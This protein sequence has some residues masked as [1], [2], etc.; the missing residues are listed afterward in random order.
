MNLIVGSAQRRFVLSSASF[1]N[2]SASFGTRE[3][4]TYVYSLLSMVPRESCWRGTPEFS[5]NRIS[6]AKLRVILGCQLHVR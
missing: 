6:M 3:S 2:R 1:V 5:C 4:V